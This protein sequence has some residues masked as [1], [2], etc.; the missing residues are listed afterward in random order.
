MNTGQP[1][2]LKSRSYQKSDNAGYSIWSREWSGDVKN[3]YAGNY[4]YGYV[5]KGYLKTSDT[6]LKL[7]AGVAQEIS[8][9]KKMGIIEADIKA[10]NSFIN[11]HYF[12]NPGDSK[13]IQ[14]GIDDFKSR[15]KK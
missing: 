7:A 1:L 8:D 14:D 13:M 6:Y 15:N 10:F 9:M 3:D 2:D 5:G 4:L 12:D 11:G